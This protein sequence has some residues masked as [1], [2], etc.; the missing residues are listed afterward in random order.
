MRRLILGALLLALIAVPAG[1]VTRGQATTAT[2]T[3][4]TGTG[5]FSINGGAAQTSFG[6]VWITNGSAFAINGSAG[7]PSTGTTL[8]ISGIGTLEVTFLFG[9]FPDAPGVDAPAPQLGY[10][11]LASPN[12]AIYLGDPTHAAVTGK[13]VL[14]DVQYHIPGSQ[15]R[16]RGNWVPV[17]PSS[18][19]PNNI[20]PPGIQPP[21][22]VGAQAFMYSVG[23]APSAGIDGVRIRFTNANVTGTTTF[24]LRMIQNPEPGTLVLFGL[25]LAGAGVLV[26]RRRRRR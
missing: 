4:F 2:I 3:Q 12:L 10:S 7:G 19:A 17:T 23:N 8:A 6:P 21:G 5:S 15:I 16:T 26:V 25:G 20:F 24:Y 14:A 13:L 9:Q 18:L 1:A 22:T 11:S